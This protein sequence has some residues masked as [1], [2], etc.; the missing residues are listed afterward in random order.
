MLLWFSSSENLSSRFQLLFH[1]SSQE[2][3]DNDINNQYT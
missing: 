2:N 3:N 1:I